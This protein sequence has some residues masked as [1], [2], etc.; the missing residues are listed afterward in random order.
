LNHQG[1]ASQEINVIF[2]ALTDPALNGFSGRNMD[3]ATPE[4]RMVVPEPST[5]LLGF[6]GLLGI[7][8][9]SRGNRRMPNPF[10]K[11]GRSICRA[12]V[13]HR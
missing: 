4:A 2:G 1:D 8:M 7:L 13:R 3:S 10:S 11:E 9:T 12:T 5:F 6:I